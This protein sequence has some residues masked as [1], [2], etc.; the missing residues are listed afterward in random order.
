MINPSAGARVNLSAT[1]EDGPRYA[2]SG[3]RLMDLRRDRSMRRVMR[4]LYKGCWT[5][6]LIEAGRT[7]HFYQS[8]SKGSDAT[9]QDVSPLVQKFNVFKLACQVHADVNAGRAPLIS[10]DEDVYPD[11]AEALRTITDR[12]LFESLYHRANRRAAK[13][14][15]ACIHA[16]IDADILSAD[17]GAVLALGDN[18]EWLPVGPIGP[19]GQPRVWE[20]RWIVA[21]TVSGR[22]QK[23]L[24]VERYW[25]PEGTVVVDNEAYKVESAETIVDLS[26][27]AKCRRVPLA[28][29]L[30]EEVA[31]EIEEIRELRVPYVPVVWLLRD[32]NEEDEPEGLIGN[33]DIDL[34]DEVF[35]AFSQW[36][37]ARS[38]H[39]TPKTRVPESMVDEETGKIDLRFDGLIDPEKAFEY[40]VAQFELEDILRSLDRAISYALA[41]MQ[42]S[43]MLLGLEPAGGVAETYESRRLKSMSTLASAQRSVPV[44]GPAMGRIF[45]VASGLESQITSFWPYGPVVFTPRPEI[46][47]ETIDR[48]REQAEMLAAGLTSTKRAIKAIHGEDDADEVL[49]EI[50]EDI[51]VRTAQNQASIFGAIGTGDPFGDRRAETTASGDGEGDVDPEGDASTVAGAGVV[52][53]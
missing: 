49:E 28:E 15:S 41:Q 27:R 52:D 35:A 38:L 31:A 24:R 45:E 26:D 51:R 30:G 10:V 1:V 50:A 36:S 9:P 6:V 7:Q 18:D 3:E 11:Q 42:V 44:Q 21:R 20:R 8:V 22:E 46:P 29:A 16:C 39:A 53:G 19:D 17:R 14:G 5:K 40:I 34:L 2:A 13:E 43:Q 33:D 23:Y 25:S 48:V 32:M 12:C 37:R 47:K 4:D